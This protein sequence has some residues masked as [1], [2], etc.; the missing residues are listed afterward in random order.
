MNS[1]MGRMLVMASFVAG[2]TNAEPPKGFYGYGQKAADKRHAK[3]RVSRKQ[4]IVNGK[5]K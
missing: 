5:R 1:T 3:N 4:R 2:F